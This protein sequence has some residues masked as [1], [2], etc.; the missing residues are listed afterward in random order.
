MR[1]LYRPKLVP[2]VLTPSG[3]GGRQAKTFI[4][5]V[6]RNSG[7][8]PYPLDFGKHWAEADVRG[9]LYAM[10][11]PQCAYCLSPLTRSDPG[12]VDHFRPKSA[13]EE[14]RQ[15]DGYWWLAYDF[16]NLLLACQKC[17]RICKR[18]QFPV[19][20]NRH[21]TYAQQKSLPW[22]RRLLLNP[23]LDDVDSWLTLDMDDRLYPIVLAPGLTGIAK[24]RA[25]TTISLLDLNDDEMYK[26]RRI[27]I[28][29]TLNDLS[30]DETHKLE[31]AACRY[32]PGSW[33]V[34]HVLRHK[35]QSDLIP[36]KAKERLFFLHEVCF[37]TVRAKDEIAKKG[38][39]SRRKKRLETLTWC[40]ATFS[41]G[42]E[43]GIIP[44]LEEYK[45]T[46]LVMAHL[47]AIKTD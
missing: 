11:G 12:D 6:E 43:S 27:L 33:V 5:L 39:T 14:N 36:T 29:Q 40:L 35:G 32:L 34:R 23:V 38:E 13:V 7:K 41:Y 17:N 28:T 45:L 21:F 18:H 15:H 10:S 19:K 26:A 47:G 2:P 42:K 3:K 30:L 44:I 46:E 8:L 16:D 31:M 37:D 1:R 22:E 24:E 25:E 20:G 4:A 9:A